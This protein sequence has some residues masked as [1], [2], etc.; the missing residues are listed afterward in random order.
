METTA[1][2]TLSGGFARHFRT[3]FR[4]P[5]MRTV[6]RAEPQCVIPKIDKLMRGYHAEARRA[7]TCSVNGKAALKVTLNK[8]LEGLGTTGR[9]PTARNPYK[10]AEQPDNSNLGRRRRRIRAR[11]RPA[12]LRGHG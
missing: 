4:P 6:P 9:C 1:R 11:W 8:V 12:E 10:Q 3:A 7:M 5:S 2:W